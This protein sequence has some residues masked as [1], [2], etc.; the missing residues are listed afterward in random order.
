MNESN[1]LMNPSLPSLGTNKSPIGEA[2]W[3]P[4]SV[5]KLFECVE[6]IRFKE[7]VDDS[8]ATGPHIFVGFLLLVILCSLVH[9]IEVRNTRN[10]VPL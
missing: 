3:L 10:T 7:G 9:K 2:I 4:A 1:E 6:L 8:D 5:G